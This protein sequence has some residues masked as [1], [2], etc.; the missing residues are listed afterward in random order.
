MIFAA[1]TGGASGLPNEQLE[2]F[3]D[4]E[5]PRESIAIGREIGSGEFGVVVEAVAVDLPRL[6][7][8]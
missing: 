6:S 8:D 7:N 1:F 2:Q 3:Q 5:V 4:I